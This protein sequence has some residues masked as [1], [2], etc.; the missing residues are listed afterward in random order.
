MFKQH[1]IDYIYLGILFNQRVKNYFTN[2][3]FHKWNTLFNPPFSLY[4]QSRFMEEET[5]AQRCWGTRL[6]SQNWGE[7]RKRA[8]PHKTLQLRLVMSLL[9]SPLL[10]VHV[11]GYI[12]HFPR[13][14]SL[15]WDDCRCFPVTK[16]ILVFKTTV[17]S[18]HLCPDHSSHCLLPD[19]LPSAVKH[20][21][22]T[23]ALSLA[24]SS[25]PSSL[26]SRATQP[27]SWFPIP[28]ANNACVYISSLLLSP[29][30]HTYLTISLPL[31]KSTEYV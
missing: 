15:A 8:W 11:P 19:P 17:T 22:Y 29:E 4:E 20:I 3:T 9:L 2:V 31:H 18:S 5:E 26:L 23:W 14:F 25:S 6:R 12:S 24:L 27:F 10:P 30:I 28:V 1:F 21:G 7:V 16:D 13:S